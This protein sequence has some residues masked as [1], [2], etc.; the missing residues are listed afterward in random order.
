M[1]LLMWNGVQSE[2][3]RRQ[4]DVELSNKPE[5]D[6]RFSVSRR[7]VNTERVLYSQ[8][9]FSFWNLNKTL[10]WKLKTKEKTLISVPE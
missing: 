7:R 4:V 8:L 1:T 10:N 3:V 9:K 2:E 6:T 5:S